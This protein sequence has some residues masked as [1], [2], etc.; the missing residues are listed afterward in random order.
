MVR[1]RFSAIRLFSFIFPP[2]MLFILVV[3]V[4]QAI[5]V[6]CNIKPYSLPSPLAVLEA[7]REHFS[8]LVLASLLTASA[9]IT[10]FALS[11]VFGVLIAIVFSQSRIVARSC[12]P[13]AIFLQTVPIVAIAPIIV[14]WFS[15]GFVSV[16]V[17]AFIIGLFP[18]ITGVTAGLVQIDSNLLEL[19]ELH[20]ASRWQTLV[21]LR[22]PSAVPNLVT[23]ARTSA[24]LSVVGAIVGETYAGFQ[25]NSRGLGYYIFMTVGQLKLD[26]L[27]AAVICSALLGLIVFVLVTAVGGTI[28]ARW[29]SMSSRE[30]ISE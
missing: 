14:T 5:V 25:G 13:Y 23:A 27:F 7:A 6:A 30:T 10:G 28:L 24:G 2:V 19:F 16:S 18:I 22:L 3:G 11:L 26:Y 8:T 20:N 1:P 17:V 12:Y 9:A 29:N 4:W 15:N 21:K